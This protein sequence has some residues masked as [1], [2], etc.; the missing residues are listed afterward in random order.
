MSITTINNNN[1]SYAPTP[2]N[3]TSYKSLSSIQSQKDQIEKLMVEDVLSNY[4]G[5]L[6]EEEWLQLA[7][8]WIDGISDEYLADACLSI[9]FLTYSF[10]TKETKT[11]RDEIKKAF[12][13]DFKQVL[14]NFTDSKGYVTDYNGLIQALKALKDKKIIIEGNNALEGLRASYD[15]LGL[16]SDKLVLSLIGALERELGVLER[17]RLERMIADQLSV[18]IPQIN[19]ALK[20][21]DSLLKNPTFSE[22]EFQ[23]AQKYRGELEELKKTI[24]DPTKFQIDEEGITN[25]QALIEHNLKPL[26]DNIKTLTAEKAPTTN[27]IPLEE[28][29][30]VRNQT[31]IKGLG[32][33]SIGIISG[34]AAYLAAYY[35]FTKTCNKLITMNAAWGMA[36]SALQRDATQLNITCQNAIA[37]FIKNEVANFDKDA[38]PHRISDYQSRGA[39]VQADFAA[40]QKSLDSIMPLV[41][42]QPKDIT[43]D[44][45]KF[46]EAAKSILQMITAYANFRI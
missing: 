23:R 13:R 12:L 39:A 14:D 20:D 17:E 24:Q 28:G 25:V 7:A 15:E 30:S 32:I 10:F 44:L 19:E 27:P 1:P 41:L 37:A 46:L 4:E 3:P 6:T 22:D 38:S 18:A 43:K 33:H 34:A 42:E 2:P 5:I 8:S 21:L 11:V 45:D 16:Y 36:L 35:S 29:E 26:I 40:Y 9:D 31:S